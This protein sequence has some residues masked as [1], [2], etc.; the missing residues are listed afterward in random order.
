[1]CLSTLL[2]GQMSFYVCA[3][4]TIYLAFKLCVSSDI[5]LK[6]KFILSLAENII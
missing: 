3:D 4:V 6:S 5:N 1:M 2:L